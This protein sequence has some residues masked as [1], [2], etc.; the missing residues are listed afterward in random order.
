MYV[1]DSVHETH[2]VYFYSAGPGRSYKIV[3]IR[4]LLAH[5]HLMRSS[6]K[7]WFNLITKVLL[8]VSVRQIDGELD[9]VPSRPKVVPE[10]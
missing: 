7:V 4:S 3:T 10:H 5:V 6:L 8:N 9:W 1:P 2:L